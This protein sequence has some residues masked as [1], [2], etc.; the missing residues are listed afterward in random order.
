MTTSEKDQA[1][2]NK[3]NVLTKRRRG[4]D[5]T[6]QLTSFG[7]IESMSFDKVF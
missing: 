6:K 4:K 7:C 1:G 3:E 5:H 2:M